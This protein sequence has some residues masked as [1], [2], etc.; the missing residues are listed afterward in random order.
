MCFPLFLTC[1]VMV[2]REILVLAFGV[3][4]PAGQLMKTCSKCRLNKPLDDFNKKSGTKD[5][6]QYHCR[7]CSKQYYKQ[8]YDSNP[9]KEK[10]RIKDRKSKIRSWYQ[11]LKRTL[12]CEVCGEDAPECIDFH[13]EEEKDFTIADAL[14]KGYS[15]Q[16]ILDEMSK[17]KVLCANCH[18]KLHAGT[19]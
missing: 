3:Q 10:D 16:R 7:T 17:C 19:L 2:T 8:Y 12:S 1:S 11:T 15:I 4:V 5:G 14:N 9:D 6:R 13:H 18:R